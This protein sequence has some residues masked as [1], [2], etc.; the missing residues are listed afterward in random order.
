[1]EKISTLENQFLDRKRGSWLDRT[2]STL[3]MELHKFMISMIA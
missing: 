3:P 1:M 2:L